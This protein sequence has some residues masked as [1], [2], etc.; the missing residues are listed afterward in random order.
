MKE[1]PQIKAAKPQAQKQPNNP[2]YY[3]DYCKQ[4]DK[5]LEDENYRDKHLYSSCPMIVLCRE[6]KQAVEVRNMNTHLL[7]ECAQHK[8]FKRCPKCKEAV[9]TR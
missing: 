7:S 3:C 1:A 5:R 4:F 6:C 2:E 8:Y 9:P